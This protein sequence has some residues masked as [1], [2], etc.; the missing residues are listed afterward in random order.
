MLLLCFI[1]AVCGAVLT[2][3]V[4]MQA[5]VACMMCKLE[6]M[7]GVGVCRDALGQR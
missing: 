6:W 7:L 5:D 1:P 3:A 4:L 2:R